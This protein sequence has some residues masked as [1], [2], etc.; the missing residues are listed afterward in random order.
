VHLVRLSGI[1]LHPTALPGRFGIGDFG[2][3]AYAFIDWLASA[4]QSLWQV[5]PLGPTGYGDS[6]YQ[7]FSAFAGNPLLISP[8]RLRDEGLL[9]ASDLENVPSFPADHVAFEKAAP[10]RMDLLARAYEN[11]ERSA[12]PSLREEFEQYCES[13]KWLDDYALFMALKQQHG[14]EHVWT[15]WEPELVSRHA[16]A[17]NL[18][19]RSLAKEINRERFWQWQFARQWRAIRAYCRERG[20]RIMGDV[21]IYV[22]HDSADVWD[23][24]DLFRL[25][26]RGNPITI[27]GVPPDYFSA[28]G[29]RW[30]NPIYD[31]DRMREHGFAWWIER[32]R[33]TMEHFDLFR[34]DHFRGFQAYW[35]IPASEETAVNGVW[36]EAPGEELFTAAQTA[37]G[38][39]PI[40]A[41]NLGVITPPVETIRKKFGFPGMS[42]LQFAFGTDAQAKD[43]KPHNFPC[44]RFAY[45][46]TH[47]NDTVMGWWNSKGGDSTRTDEQIRVEKK[48][49]LEY[50]GVTDD[51]Q[52]NWHLIRALLASV[53]AGAVMPIQDVLG[54]GKESRFN[55][56]GTMGGNWTW[57]LREGELTPALAHRLKR[58]VELYDR[59]S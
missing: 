42:I 1:L 53:A 48:H 58:L 31:W 28:T 21:P 51:G 16:G 22:A 20:I 7:L 24:P 4:G 11:F 8:E 36:K 6:P 13:Q 44:D 27:A 30:G 49:A 56:P 18:W 26:E 35:E 19:R 25:D 47:D 57:R 40:V 32:F 55:A 46:G 50:L 9:S 10:V 3:G 38:E 52:M 39:L 54:L 2:P 12:S 41:E 34:L 29:Q 37:L 15:E 59:Q 23:C 45:T 43:F 17:L 33:A 14:V 5:L